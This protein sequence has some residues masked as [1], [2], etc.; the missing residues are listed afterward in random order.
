MVIAYF[1]L[2]KKNKIQLKS[3]AQHMK[4]ASEFYVHTISYA[5]AL[6]FYQIQL[7]IHHKIYRWGCKEVNE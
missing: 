4:L 2:G 1:F 7:N 5:I 3:Q 6:F